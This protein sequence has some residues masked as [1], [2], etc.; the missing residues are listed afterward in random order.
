MRQAAPRQWLR[1]VRGDAL[2][3]PLYSSDVGQRLDDSTVAGQR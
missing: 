3:K 1:D 2:T